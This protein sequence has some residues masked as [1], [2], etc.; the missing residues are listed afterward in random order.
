M[1]SN[2]LAENL[3]PHALDLA[4]HLLAEQALAR[5]C[6]ELAPALR[7]ALE[8]R[9]PAAATTCDKATHQG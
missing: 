6:V 9:L 5:L 8:C 7:Q 1:N 2:V 3:Q 4:A